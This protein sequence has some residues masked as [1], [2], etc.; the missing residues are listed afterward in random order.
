[1]IPG[2]EFK[3]PTVV[4]QIEREYPAMTAEY[5]KIIMEQYETFCL[6][7]SNYGPGNISVGTSL[8]IGI[9]LCFY[10]ENR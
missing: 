8:A 2:Y 1:M 10:V 6:K 9:F 7:Q 3:N 5:K 4:E